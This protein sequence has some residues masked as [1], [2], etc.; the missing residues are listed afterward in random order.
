M[1]VDFEGLGPAYKS[2][3][4]ACVSII[5]IIITLIFFYVKCMTLYNRSHVEI[6]SALAERVHAQ[7]FKFSSEQD[8]FVAAAITAYDSETESP[9]DLHKY[10]ELVFYH[11]GWNATD[12]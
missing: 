7:D 1:K 6:T 11:E 3:M 2:Y 9:A 5:F 8:F 4:G 12:G 10:G